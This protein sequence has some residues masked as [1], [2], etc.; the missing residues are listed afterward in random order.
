M[1]VIS[2]NKTFLLASLISI[3]LLPIKVNA[4]YDAPAV[5]T[6][7]K[8]AILMDYETGSVLFE[9]DAYEAMPPASMSKLMTVYLIFERLKD[10][11][12]SLDDEFEVSEKAWREGGAITDGS[13]MFLPLHS[14][15][16]IHDL[17]RGIIVQSGNDACIV[18]AENISGSEANFV[19]EMNLKAK[20][21]GLKNSVFANSSGLP[22]PNHYMSAYD[23]ALLT[24]RIIKD[25][26]EY[27][28]IFSEKSFKFNGIPQYNRNPLLSSMPEADGM[29]TGHTKA[30]GYG[31]TAT[32]KRDN[33]RLISVVNG[34]NKMSQ[35]GEESKMLLVWGFMEFDNY[36]LFSKSEEVGKIATWFGQDPYVSAVTDEDI[37]MSLPRGSAKNIKISMTYNEPITAP[38]NKGDKIGKLKISK[39]ENDSEEFDLFAAS[40][41]RKQGFI[42][43]VFSYFKYK[44]FGF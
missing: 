31:L 23:L 13:T 10:G 25:F 34:L 5:K 33:R 14:K 17:L 6:I 27:F 7:A 22:N 16:K 18:A 28:P 36:K 3:L 8:H 2:K 20:E 44:L 37:V 24:R 11:R 35:R 32:A 38:I 43:R 1:N 19:R 4:S 40:D 21:I 42:N 30:S 26:P 12:L 41:V 39:S 29:K 9:K 15:I